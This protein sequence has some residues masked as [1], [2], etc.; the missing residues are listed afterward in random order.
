MYLLYLKENA[1]LL[2]SKYRNNKNI[3]SNRFIKP[4]N[5]LV[6]RVICH[7]YK[8]DQKKL[9]YHSTIL[10]KPKFQIESI[11]AKHIFT[12]DILATHGTPDKSV[13]LLGHNGVPI[14]FVMFLIIVANIERS[15][16]LLKIIKY[17]NRNSICQTRLHSFIH[18]LCI[19][20]IHT[21]SI[22]L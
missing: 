20:L 6:T 5:N 1:W 14:L 22:N 19:L 17:Y 7:H 11:W 18:L 21:R 10:D 16:I 15:F 4:H 9:Y 13:C 2:I 3:N 8:M 12:S